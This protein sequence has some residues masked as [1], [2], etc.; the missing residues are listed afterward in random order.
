MTTQLQKDILR[1]HIQGLKNAEISKQLNCTTQYVGQTVRQTRKDAL[2]ERELTIP[3]YFKAVS[4][5]IKTQTQLAAW[6]GVSDRT[7][8][9][10]EKKNNIKEIGHAYSEF[11]KSNYL[12]NLE[13][14]LVE[15]SDLLKQC[16]PSSPE[17]GK[18][19]RL[20]KVLKFDFLT[21]SQKQK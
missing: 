5:G 12:D 7:I 11:T 13:K 3:N 21:N 8:R 18:I 10:F 16:N 17:L 15:I 20:I 19:D 2:T 9:N 4:R 14:N 1:L 6:F